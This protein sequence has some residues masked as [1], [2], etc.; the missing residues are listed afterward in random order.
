MISIIL[1]T[2]LGVSGISYVSYVT[3][4]EI[5]KERIRNERIKKSLLYN[6]V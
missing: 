6:E 4:K 5:I 3:I 2:F 1:F